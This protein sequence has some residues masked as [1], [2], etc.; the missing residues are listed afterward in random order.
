VFPGIRR[1]TITPAV[2]FIQVARSKIVVKTNPKKVLPK[3]RDL[4]L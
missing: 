2:P 1:P 3:E 4:N